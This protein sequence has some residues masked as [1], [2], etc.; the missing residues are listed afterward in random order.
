LSGPRLGLIGSAF[1]S[2]SL[3]DLISQEESSMAGSATNPDNWQGANLSRQSKPSKLSLG[4]KLGE[5]YTWQPVNSN[6]GAI[7]GKS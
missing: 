3:R 1:G 2:T 6:G 4:A 7:P 5:N